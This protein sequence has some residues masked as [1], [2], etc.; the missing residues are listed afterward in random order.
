M[1]ALQPSNQTPAA[2]KLQLDSLG[3]RVA[4]D[5]ETAMAPLSFRGRD[6]VRL[7]QVHEPGREF[8]WDLQTWTDEHWHVLQEWLLEDYRF[9]IGHN[10]AYD[11]RCLRG[12]GMRVKATLRDT[13]VASQL[14]YNGCSWTLKSG[15]FSLAGCCM[16]ELGVEV[17][18]TYQS[19][20]WM[21][22]DLEA[23]AAA[24]E[25][26]MEDVRLTFRLHQEL[27]AKILSEGMGLVYR[28]EC[29][30]LQATVEMEHTGFGV[31]R[32]H[33]DAVIE[34]LGADVPELLDFFVES[35]DDQLQQAGAEPL[36]REGS[37][38]NLRA[39]ASGSVRAGTKRHAGF[40]PNSPRQVLEKFALLDIHPQDPE[41]KASLN[42]NWLSPWIGQ[43]V[44]RSYVDYKK[45][46][47]R[48]TMMKSLLDK[49]NGGERIY[50][51]FNQL[52][53]GTG[54]Y[55]SSDPNLQNIPREPRFRD[56]FAA[57]EGR[58]LVVMDVKNMEMGVA[59][60]KPIADEKKVQEALREGLDL[61]TFTAHLIFGLPIEQ[62]EKDQR[63]RA[64]SCNFG[65]LYGS[66]AQGLCNYFATFGQFISLAEAKEFRQAWL[67]AYPGFA[68]WH[69]DCADKV[70]SG[71]VVMVDGRRRSLEG[72][73]AR[74]TVIANNVVQGTSASIVKRTMAALQQLLGE[75]F[76]TARLVAQ[77]H[78]EIVVECDEG[79]GEEI[80]ELMKETLFRAG[81]MIIGPSVDMLG[82]GA[83][84]KSWGAAK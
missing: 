80:L 20:K 19:A 63:Q 26:A 5:M 36:P 18:K 60:S 23:D 34:E 74:L 2:L 47:K 43:P 83:V 40:N 81:R 35:L 82:E 39:K 79:R 54:R 53:T 78:D 33:L 42:Q 84:V 17:D 44:V 8:A 55:S 77:V 30:V 41:G 57:P 52:R 9:L 10:I 1:T 14:L 45:A 62:V 70:P 66:G 11:L 16:R 12:C 69:Q 4:L 28:M 13:M 65:L 25:Y 49:L 3:Q 24:L 64:K 48:L 32:D 27:E 56:V 38:V 7:L 21:E 31:D 46:E 37:V 59:A 6:Q 61:H 72:G 50:A 22:L 71:E 29:D 68:A 73:M 58:E 75:S 67:D 51:N 15:T 76:H